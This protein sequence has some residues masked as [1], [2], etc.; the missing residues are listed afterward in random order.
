MGR[1]VCCAKLFTDGLRN[2]MRTLKTRW[3]SG[4]PHGNHITCGC[5]W[6]RN[7]DL[8]QQ[9]RKD[10]LCSRHYWVFPHHNAGVFTN[11]KSKHYMG[12]H[13]SESWAQND[14]NRHALEHLFCYKG[15]G[16]DT[17]STGPLPV[18]SQGSITSN[19]NQ[20]V[21]PS[22]PSPVT[23]K[24]TVMPPG[25]QAVMS[26]FQK[27]SPTINVTSYCLIQCTLKDLFA[28]NNQAPEKRIIALY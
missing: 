28:E 20:N 18:R 21:H 17:R 23:R 10:R 14:R 22:I 15:K 24:F 3:H 6:S 4:F 13:R 11:L 16:D 5:E 12:S 19:P 8:S 1:A 2:H 25:G 27:S 26:S 9:M 7:N